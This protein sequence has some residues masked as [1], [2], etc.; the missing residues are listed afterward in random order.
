MPKTIAATP[1]KATSHQ[2]S[3]SNLP[4]VLPSAGLTIFSAINP[5]SILRLNRNPSLHPKFMIAIA[6]Q[7]PHTLTPSFCPTA[8][9]IKW[10]LHPL[11]RREKFLASRLLILLELF[12]N[13]LR[14]VDELIRQRSVNSRDLRRD[15]ILK[16]LK[17]TNA[18]DN[19]ASFERSQHRF[20]R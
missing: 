8:S 14:S 5:P 6:N 7:I 10:G 9:F 18:G 13:S 20:Q 17:L 2:V 1:R 11:A 16:C 19:I 3:A 15:H 12:D 4:N